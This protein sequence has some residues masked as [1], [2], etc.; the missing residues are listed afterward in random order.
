MLPADPA[1]RTEAVVALHRG[2]M[3]EHAKGDH[4][5]ANSI[6]AVYADAL[7]DAG[8]PGHESHAQRILS[9]PTNPEH[10]ENYL[11]AGGTP[12]YLDRVGSRVQSL[13]GVGSQR[14][15]PYYAH[16]LYELR[17]R[18]DG[19]YTY[20][21]VDS[22]PWVRSDVHGRTAFEGVPHDYQVP[23]LGAGVRNGT[24]VPPH[25]LA[26]HHAAAAVRRHLGQT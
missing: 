4:G 15:H 5:F 11:R 7:D 21:L 23:G 18:G 26:Y 6:R 24:P 12:E 8:A 3:A 25:V 13:R 16:G 2:I 22:G 20:R 17:Q 10:I 19:Q 14:G 1:H 9:D